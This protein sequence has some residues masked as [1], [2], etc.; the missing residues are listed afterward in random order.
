MEDLRL[1]TLPLAGLAGLVLA[2]SGLAALLGRDLP[3][4]ARAA[5]APL[6]GA[7][8]LA[9]TSPLA[10][11]GVPV[12]WLGL[13]WLAG[14]AAMT[15]A[16]RARARDLL[17]GAGLPFAAAAAPFFLAAAPRLGRGSWSAAALGN[18]DVY[19]WVSQARAFVDGP[20]AGPAGLHPDR[21]A[22]ER[23]ADQ[24]WAVALPVSDAL[25]ALIS[26]RAPEDVYGAIAVIVTVLAPLAA[27][28]CA[29]GVLAWTP[30]RSAVATGI[31]GVNASL[32]NAGYFGWHGQLLGTAFLALAA[33]ALR[34]GLEGSR[35]MQILAALATAAALG[36]YRLPIAPVAAAFLGAVVAAYLVAH[37]GRVRAA[38]RAAAATAA[39]AALL[40]AASLLPLVR[41]LPRFLAEQT[42]EPGWELYARGPVAQVLGLV[43][44]PLEP[45]SA[46]GSIEAAF[47]GLLAFVLLAGGAVAV[48]RGDGARHDFLLGVA[49]VVLGGGLILSLPPFSPYLS[50]KYLA[51]GTPFVVLLAVAGLTGRQRRWHTV[52]A[53]VAA[54]ALVA[55]STASLADRGV[56]YLR[57]P[58]DLEGLAAT[59]TSLPP[60]SVISVEVS[61]PWI[62]VWTLYELRAVPLSLPEPS[63]YVAGIGSHV[64]AADL[65]RDF[66]Y[67][68]TYQTGRDA[69]WRGAGLE[70]ARA[71]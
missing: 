44:P 71:T 14:G 28:V 31:V 36:S 30:V 12:R 11:S 48:A 15:V 4:D 25:L 35:R 42:A 55:A 58:P 16:L 19:L 65:R 10:A 7:V 20:A 60:G 43:P 69:L 63:S 9:A 37:P 34:V 27:Y 52:A 17:R 41:G 18:G 39:F 2:G 49:V 8:L 62:Q 61:D 13:A 26:G 22:F 40:A 5:L 70:L 6:C 23:I 68:L 47:A 33:V 29:R 67:V 46:E 53:G 57:T 21:F 1:L 54:L 50:V 38:L 45:T 66:D 64:D 32:V 59:A 24:G 51:Y 3:R 56:R